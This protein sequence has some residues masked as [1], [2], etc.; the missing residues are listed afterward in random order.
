MSKTKKAQIMFT[1]THEVK[2]LLTKRATKE[3][4]T[5]SN[6]VETLVVDAIAPEENKAPAPT[7]E[8]S[9]TGVLYRN[10]DE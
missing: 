3:N 6:L 2:D 4:R 7:I 9:N 5:V 10:S 8:L 1:C